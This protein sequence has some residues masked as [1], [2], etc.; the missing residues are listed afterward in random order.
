MGTGVN[1]SLNGKYRTVLN[2]RNFIK[3]AG[4]AVFSFTIMKSSLVRGTQ[5]NSKINLGMIGC[6]G[7]GTWIGNLFREHGGYEITAAADYFQDRVDTFGEKFGIGAPRRYTGLACYKRLLDGGVDA[8]AVE[9]PPYFHPEQA[10]AGVEAGV[11]VYLAKPIAVDVPGCLLVGESGKKATQ[12]NLCFLVDFQTRANEFYRE[13]V[14]RVQY[15]EIGRIISGEASYHCGPTW[16]RMFSYFEGG[17]IK[18]ED[19][20]RA[21]GLDRVLSGDVI[22]EQNIHALDVASWIMDSPPVKAC[23]SGGRYRKAGDCWD[24]FSVIFTYPNDVLVTFNSKQYGKGHDDILCRMYGET[25]T[26]DTHY[27]GSV[28]IR[29]DRPYKGGELPN[30]FTDGVKV[31]IADFHTNVTSAIYANT[32]V[33][34][35]VQS[36]LTTILGRKAAYAHGEVTWN[37]ILRENE[38]LDPRLEGLKA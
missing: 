5:A 30:L 14:K 21:W 34:P 17:A 1:E 3:S 2:R 4:A 6:G 25:G 27:F 29:G 9:S 8:I 37:D 35:S 36:N 28:S 38:R 20:L 32:T 24:F 18:P 10:A 11:H 13:A 15:G 12:K 19:R 31:N 26:I 33:G 22:T 16:N 23:G 7:R